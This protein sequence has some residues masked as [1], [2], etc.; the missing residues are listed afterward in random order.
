MTSDPKDA[1]DAKPETLDEAV[2]L[3]LVEEEATIGKREVVTGR[4]HVRTVT[5]TTEEILTETLASERVEVERVQVNRYVEPGA[6]PPEPRVEGDT[7]ILPVLEEVLVVEKRLLIKEELHITRHRTTE[8]VETP[9]T[10]RK[11]RAVVK[12]EPADAQ[13]TPTPNDMPEA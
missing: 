11:Q 13:A 10:L 9:V 2:V 12:R 8:A 7:T 6:A 5:E 1:F 3:P 4:V